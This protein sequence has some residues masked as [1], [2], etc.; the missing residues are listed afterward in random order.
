MN[1][2][3]IP[4]RA[5]GI[6]C[7][8]SSLPSRFGIGCFDKAA[9]DF[10]DW[11]V[12]A[13]Q[14]IWQILPLGHSGRSASPYKCYSAFAGHPFYIDLT[15]FIEDGRLTEKECEA[16][17]GEDKHLVD[18]ELLREHRLC[19][20]RKVYAA[21]T[22]CET[23][24]FK[25]FV[26]DNS[27]VEP[28]AQFMAIKNSLGGVKL[29]DWPQELRNYK[30][31]ALRAKLLEVQ[32]EVQFYEFLQYMFMH[33]WQ[34]LRA[35]ANNRGIRILGDMPIYVSDDSADLWIDPQ[36]FQT[37][38]DGSL[39]NVAGCP[40]DAFS[41]TGQVW[42][43]PLYDWPIHEQEG[44]A[45]WIHR[46][47]ASFALFDIV[48]IDHFRGF[49]AYYVIDAQTRDAATG[50][51]EKGPGYKLFSALKEALGE[52]EIIVEDLGT[53][54]DEVKA[55]VE[56]TGFPNMRILEFGFD[57]R[58]AED[59]SFYQPHSYP[60]NCVAYTGTHDNETLQQWL[61]T[62]TPNEYETVQAYLVDSH[63]SKRH[64]N[65]ALIALIMRS[66]ANLS[67]VPLQDWLGLG[68]AAR[69][70]TPSTVGGT[71]WAWRVST[72]QLSEDC[73]RHIGDFTYRFGRVAAKVNS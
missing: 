6:L 23:Q 56:K 22:E 13:K 28:Y 17:A 43:N 24:A 35:Y 70:N 18:Y 61:N 54:T 25:A 7:A 14:S 71:N 33:Q 40:P 31:D 46:M 27:W 37:C 15:P 57:A 34:A 38:E 67:V 16:C 9:Y 45:W 30:P 8:V 65:D 32:D 39:A 73:A 11:L 55:L 12:D 63:T 36:L 42:G 50:H 26:K 68:A 51:W 21:G 52:R 59:Q 3:A 19:L 60:C 62:I 10:V 41:A 49:E 29:R 47:Q 48:R 69:M 64:L 72:D 58:S 1:S 4:G 20:L 2:S 5:S 53:M 44:F 66:A